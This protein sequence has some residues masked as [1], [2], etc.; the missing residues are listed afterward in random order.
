MN[1]TYEE[2]SYAQKFTISRPKIGMVGDGA[3]DLMALK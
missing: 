3:N 2:L 1:Q